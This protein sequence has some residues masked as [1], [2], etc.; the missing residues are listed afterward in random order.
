MNQ[1]FNPEPDYYHP[2]GIQVIGDFLVV[3][4]EKTD[5][6]TTSGVVNPSYIKVYDI[7]T[8]RKNPLSN[9]NPTAA[10]TL[11]NDYLLSFFS[12]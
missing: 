6:S 11:V 10:L 9:Q 7:S 4:L 12:L 3:G 2:S 5:K 8:L 1:N